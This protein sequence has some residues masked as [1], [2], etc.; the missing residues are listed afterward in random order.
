M[1]PKPKSAKNYYDDFLKISEIRRMFCDSKP[2]VSSV[3]KGFD[4]KLEI[5]K[6][7]IGE[8]NDS[9]EIKTVLSKLDSSTKTVKTGNGIEYI[10]LKQLHVFKPVFS[11]VF[12]NSSDRKATVNRA[13]KVVL[14]GFINGP[15]MEI[16]SLLDELVILHKKFTGRMDVHGIEQ[17]EKSR[18]PRLQH[19]KYMVSAYRN[20][21]QKKAQ[22]RS[23]VD[24]TH[25]LNNDV[26]VVYFRD[27]KKQLVRAILHFSY[28]GLVYAENGSTS[29]QKDEQGELIISNHNIFSLSGS[30]TIDS[31]YTLRMQLRSQD[32]TI[33]IQS[34]LPF[35]EKIE[36]QDLSEVDLLS[37]SRL[38]HHFPYNGEKVM[39]ASAG[40]MVKLRGR[41]PNDMLA[42]V[43]HN[44]SQLTQFEREIAKYTGCFQEYEIKDIID[45]N[46]L[47]NL[48][49][50]KIQS[51]KKRSFKNIV[52][53]AESLSIKSRNQPHPLEETWVSLSRIQEFDNKLAVSYWSFSLDRMNQEIQV[54]RESYNRKLYG[55][56][57]EC[58]NHLI[59][60]E[61][62]ESKY[63]K[64]KFIFGSEEKL[65]VKTSFRV[66]S[67][68]DEIEEY[69][70]EEVIEEVYVI[71]AYSSI[72]S[73]SK[74]L[75][76]RELIFP[77]RLMCP[78][79]VDRYK[80]SKGYHGYRMKQS[81]PK[82]LGPSFRE[83]EDLFSISHD[84]F[85]RENV[86]LNHETKLY[87]GDISDTKNISKS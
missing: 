85:M 29:K 53:R 66:P 36:G 77:I 72:T 37:C 7:E 31:F 84:D 71:K 42:G 18:L 80:F 63:D 2:S 67:L 41:S 20:Y 14:L 56:M 47:V 45:N 6:K 38:E 39:H 78:E 10:G 52:S 75:T 13:I 17:N 61:L 49:E 25:L 76:T 44:M 81:N 11:R 87:L 28:S 12:L 74:C 24:R 23:T 19:R 46:H 51:S 35:E 32:K 1:T 65:K 4:V 40:V 8:L 33:S 48:T 26:W 59:W 57:R 15:L 55:F 60:F 22:R 54:I 16:I 5:R 83:G 79:F 21:D 43:V 70:S 62:N 69:D 86:R 9:S 3:V 68:D 27:A 50:A 64:P 34:I 30:S 73:K 58:D 82:Y